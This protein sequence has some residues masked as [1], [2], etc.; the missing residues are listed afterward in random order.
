MIVSP[1]RRGRGWSEGLYD[2]GFLKDRSRYSGEPQVTLAGFDRALADIDAAVR[3]LLARADVDAR[4]VIIGGHSRG[5]M[6]SLAYAA[7]YSGRVRGVLNF[8][9]GW[10]ST[11]HETFSAVHQTIAADAAKS[12]TPTLWLYGGKD[13]LYGISDIRPFF[14]AFE[15]AGGVGEFVSFPDAG[16]G[17]M[18]ETTRWRQPVDHFMQELG[19]R[20]F[21]T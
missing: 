11:W 1:Q 20:E 10:L 17:L 15:N 2:E 16:H 19:F 3:V 13:Q 4:Q 21:A 9:G 5:G 14:D 18:G 7:R 12:D 8:V 6:L